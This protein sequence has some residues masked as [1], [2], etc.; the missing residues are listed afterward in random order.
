MSA[1]IQ[2]GSMLME[3][4]AA[5]GGGLAIESEP[6]AQGW[7]VLSFLNGRDLDRRARATKWSFFF[8][9]EAKR[10]MFF[11]GRSGNGMFKALTR[12]LAKSRSQGFNCLEVT[13]ILDKSF[14]GIRYTT[15]VAHSRHL[16]PPGRIDI[17]RSTSSHDS[18]PM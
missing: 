16:Q 2:I 5:N 9:A 17:L 14:L 18:A 3:S 13:E 7:S 10:E 8:L 6:F 4:R 12:I 1:Q 15:I 11:G